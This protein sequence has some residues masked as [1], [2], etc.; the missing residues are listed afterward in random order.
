MRLLNAKELLKWN[1]TWL[2]KSSLYKIKDKNKKYLCGWMECYTT[3]IAT[4]YF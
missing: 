2:N 4:I 1:E 3:V